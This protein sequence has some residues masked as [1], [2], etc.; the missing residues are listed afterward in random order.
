[1][2]QALAETLK[3]MQLKLV[4]SSDAPVSQPTQPVVEDTVSTMVMTSESNPHTP[5]LAVTHGD[6]PVETESQPL[7]CN[8]RE[9]NIGEEV[10][11]TNP[12][13]QETPYT[14]T[15]PIDLGE[16]YQEVAMGGT[17]HGQDNNSN[18]ADDVDAFLFSIEL[19]IQQ[20]LI[21]EG[22]H[23]QLTLPTNTNNSPEHLS[24]PQSFSQRKSDRLAKKAALNVGKDPFQVAE[25]LLVKKIR[26]FSGRGKL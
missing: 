17:R 9:T 3:L 25:D 12:N 14:T 8:T 4:M 16:T 2:Q 19:P 5:S 11:Q 21:Q 7:Q 20:P 10:L 24:P 26:G 23:T 1:M 13:L 18:T 6:P 22:H 15:E